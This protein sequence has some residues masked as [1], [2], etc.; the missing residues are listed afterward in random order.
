MKLTRVTTSTFAM[1]PGNRVVR[2]PSAGEDRRVNRSW[3]EQILG[4]LTQDCHTVVLVEGVSDQIAI[5]ALA[6]RR[7]RAL[8]VEG[9]HILAMGGATNIG[10]VLEQV[11]P[12]GLDLRLAG[13]CDAGEEEH[14]RR[15]LRRAG[16]DCRSR[17][18]LQALG[19]FVCQLDLEDELIRAVGT[20]AVEQIIAADGR[21]PSFRRLQRQPAQR[22]QPVNHQLRRF[23]AARS[24]HKNHYARLLVDALDLDQVPPP[25]DHLLN[26]VT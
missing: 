17:L 7:G 10:H 24:G 1:A 5:E 16:F 23:I 8:S 9:V 18:D 22:T 21:L 15:A 6:R 2:D 19:F 13:L 12:A 3:A 20:A 25:L 14:V 26:R 11:G 4:Q